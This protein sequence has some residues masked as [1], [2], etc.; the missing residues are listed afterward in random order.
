MATKHKMEIPLD[1][2]TSAALKRLTLEPE[3]VFANDKPD[4]QMVPHKQPETK[5]ETSPQPT[6][7]SN[8]VKIRTKDR[9][10]YAEK[11]HPILFRA[12]SEEKELFDRVIENSKYKSIQHFFEGEVLSLLRKMDQG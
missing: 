8:V 10:P 12:T 7:E 3:V 4:D 11:K 5:T 1:T 6:A 9:I 2:D